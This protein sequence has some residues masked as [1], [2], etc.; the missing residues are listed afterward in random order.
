ML[1]R[2]CRLRSSS[3]RSGGS[4]AGARTPADVSRGICGFVWICALALAPAASADTIEATEGPPFAELPGPPEAGDAEFQ[5]WAERIAA[6][7]GKWLA[8]LWTVELDGDPTLE[9]VARL[10]GEQEVLTLLIE[11]PDSG[12]RWK[13]SE[14]AWERAPTCPDVGTV[15]WEHADEG[16]VMADAAA[17]EHRERWVGLRD[18]R[19]VEAAYW[20]ARSSP[21]VSE[22]EV[23]W[24]LRTVL[25]T[26]EDGSDEQRRRLDR[27][28][29]IVTMGPATGEPERA[30]TWVRSGGLRWRGDRD[31]SLS[32]GGH[33]TQDGRV[34]LDV[35]VHDDHRIVAPD[36]SSLDG[37]DR[38]EIWWAPVGADLRDPFGDESTPRGLMV[39]PL[40]DGRL[41]TAWIGQ[42]TE[43]LPEVSGDLERL[44]V[45]L[46]V[47]AP[48]RGAAMPLTVVFSDVDG[49]RGN[50]SSIIAT[51]RLQSGR[52]G[53]FGWLVQHA[54]GGQFPE[55]G[56][57]LE[58]G[59]AQPEADA[60]AAV[61]QDVLESED[62]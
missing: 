10:C 22:Q 35:M 62:P 41:H 60:T 31:A 49:R 19:L 7:E 17:G 34:R 18:G 38:L 29:W 57:L 50:P 44:Y 27:E 6:Q 3:P 20:H 54:E 55:L 52:P 11:D 2:D 13:I 1:A 5:R 39:V 61:A 12:R 37:V 16:L 45:T 9:R 26:I 21:H 40:A 43:P 58:P 30:S 32:L 4:P 48:L 59:E 47:Q 42:S 36:A 56:E 23:R 53:T 8:A 46:P 24:D 28:G 14:E 15:S 33:A 25:G 51:S